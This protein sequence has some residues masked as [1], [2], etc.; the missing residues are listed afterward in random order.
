LSQRNHDGAPRTQQGTTTRTTCRRSASAGGVRP[1]PNFAEIVENDVRAAA[2]P[3]FGTLLRSYRLTAGLSQEA[4]AER[5]GMSAHGISALE[6][7]YRRTP[8]RG[9][10]ALLAGALAL[11]NGQCREF[12]VAAARSV[13]LGGRTRASVTVGPWPDTITSNLPIA[14]TSFVGRTAELNEITALVRDH[15]L[16]TLTGSGGVGKTQMA[17][18]VGN[19][20]IDAADGSVWFVE[21]APVGDPSL[22]VTAIASTLGVQEVPNRPLLGTLLVYL[23]NKS[24]LLI[25]DNCEHV[26]NE[27]AMVA[28][29]LLSGCPHL[30]ILATSRELLRA[31]GEYAYRLGSLGVPPPETARRL[32]AA[33]A[34]T[35]GATVLFSD[36]ARAVDH[37]FTITDQIAPTV[38]EICRRLDGIPLAIELAAARATLLSVGALAEGLDDRFQILAS[39]ERTAVPRQQTMRAAIDW[40]Y[41]LLS[42]PEQRLLERLSV[43]VNGCTFA[44]AAAVCA[45]EEVAKS[46]I[47]GL[48]SSLVDKSLVVA[49]FEGAQPRYRLLESFREYARGK[50]AAR[51]EWHVLSHRHALAFLGLA[52]ELGLAYDTKP[53]EVWFDLAQRELDNWRAA[54]QWALIHHGDVLLGQR[55]VGRLHV[56]W[57]NLACI[58]GRRWLRS[59]LELVDRQ[60]PTSVLASLSYAEASIAH[61]LREYT[62]ELDS[63][64]SAIE[65]YRVAGDSL[66]IARAQCWAGHA[67]ECL[68][69]IEEAKAL[70]QEALTTARGLGNNRVLADALRLLAFAGALGDEVVAARGYLAE[71]LLICEATGAKINGAEA[72][73]DLA[74]AEW[75]AGNAELALAHAMDALAACRE[76]GNSRLVPF[77]DIAEILIALER[78]DEAEQYAREALDIGRELQHD[79]IVTW[80]L[81]QLG[82]IAALRPQPVAERSPNL[83]ARAGRILGFVD[84]R[85]AETVQPRLWEP[86]YDRAIAL[87]R[88]A[89]GVDAVASFMTAG[90]TITEDQ[91]VEEALEI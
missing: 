74:Y 75:R 52:E 37:R 4:L 60:T 5:A 51:G 48:L 73:G 63:S 25:L 29:T 67:L 86:E 35:Y 41:N 58:E 40:S 50:L 54:L 56:A 78:Y 31:A 45:G 30:R 89:I 10:L 18:H 19:G 64:E 66:G 77:T 80:A 68:G 8:Q 28:N 16:V 20:V 84:A 44:T 43:F 24:P 3:D 22:V 1:G 59:A 55:L 72:I 87:L 32:S 6:R 82:A 26:I 61:Q 27:A 34:A 21:L 65:R 46:D 53:D 79:H 7:G 76:F 71:A 2:R 38:A 42:V 17:L 90:A 13:L 9:T 47:L 70:L 11:S 23:R 49:D 39:G 81:Q 88:D 69:R 33:D 83:Y 85:R 57:E 91:A 15:R 36:R 62:T 12:E 14:L